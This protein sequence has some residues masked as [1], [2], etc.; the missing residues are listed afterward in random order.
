MAH[1]LI[2][3]KASNLKDLCFAE[4]KSIVDQYNKLLGITQTLFS[5]EG[6]WYNLIIH[7]E[8]ILVQRMIVQDLIAQLGM[9]VDNDQEKL[10]NYGN[11][12]PQNEDL[13]ERYRQ[14]KAEND[15]FK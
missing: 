6:K 15:R 9:A 2:K 5:N 10:D 14:L 13:V 3:N 4:I 12:I 7:Q 8:D 1:H 11:I